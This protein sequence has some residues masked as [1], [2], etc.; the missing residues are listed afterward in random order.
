MSRTYKWLI[1]GAA[2][3]FVAVFVIH[4]FWIDL[5]AW[6]AALITVLTATISGSTDGLGLGHHDSD[7][8]PIPPVA[9]AV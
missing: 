4:I 6:G 9:G 3:G 7:P 5:P 1:I 2:I 8:Q